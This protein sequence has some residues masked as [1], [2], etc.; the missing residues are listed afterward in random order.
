MVAQHQ[1]AVQT[2]LSKKTMTNPTDCTLHYAIAQ[3]GDEALLISHASKFKA[4]QF[5]C[6]NWEAIEASLPP[7]VRWVRLVTEEKATMRFRLKGR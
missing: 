5:F 7:E 1:G 6:G 3:L 4:I 2:T